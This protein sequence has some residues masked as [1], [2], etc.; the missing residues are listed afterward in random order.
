MRKPLILLF[1][2]APL[3]VG[4]AGLLAAAD[5]PFGRK[6][7]REYIVERLSEM[8]GRELE[9]NGEI[10]VDLSWRPSVRLEDVRV[11]NADW[12]KAPH[13]LELDA[14]VVQLEMRR[15]LQGEVRLP[16]LSLIGPKLFLEVSDAGKP[17]WILGGEKQTIVESAAVPGG[18]PGN[19]P[20]IDLLE[21]DKGELAYLDQSAPAPHWI[22]G[23]IDKAGG[24]LDADGVDFAAGGTLGEKPFTIVLRSASLDDLRAG[25]NPNPVYLLATTGSSRLLVDGTMVAPFKLQGI[26]L[27]LEA[28]GPGFNALP[29]VT[30]LPK[31]PSFDLSAHLARDAGPWHLKDL[32]AAI[33]RSGMTG[34]LT[35]DLTGER[36]RISADLS[37][38]TLAVGELLALV[39]KGDEEPGP[40]DGD[41]DGDR[42]RGHRS[43]W[44]ECPRGGHRLHR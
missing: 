27:A 18:K 42:D 26:D 1:L 24:S 5:L 6:E 23:R 3:L 21:I 40:E 22:R 33:G 10:T 37:A 32:N 36:P 15:L 41:G 8:A 25:E 44:P 28:H 43:V 20:R 2:L 34:T 31:S 9:I 29:L 35:L 4:A 12:G 38:K 11:A 17:N 13:L 19:L 30:G 16:R 14:L 7:I 39:P